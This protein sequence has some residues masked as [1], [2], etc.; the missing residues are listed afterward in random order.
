MAQ[1]F[2]IPTDALGPLTLGERL[3]AERKSQGLS[4]FE[5]SARCGVKADY[6]SA[7]EK[8]KHSE[9][10]TLGYAI[11][12]VRAYARELGVP[13]ADAVAQFKAETGGSIKS[14]RRRFMPAAKLSTPSLMRRLPRGSIPA[15][16]VIAFV[17]MMGTWYGVQLQT[18]AAPQP[19]IPAALTA[20][21]TTASLPVSDDIVTLRTTAPSWIRIRDPK[22]RIIAN[23][24][25][26]TG[27]SWQGQTGQ[28]Y[29][30]SVRD[31]GAVSVFIGETPL[32]A[33]GLA[34]E[35]VNDFNLQ[36]LQ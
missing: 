36:G 29:T 19:S 20:G 32:G 10:P 21:A 30:V 18:V 25:F 3:A 13:S 9:L 17:V 7:I 24:V 2:D 5:V 28:D 11:G 12:Y 34:G 8:S 33:L 35:P 22:G 31:G 26:V 1:Q 23:R 27:E 15:L 14:S 16:G 6:L 4:V